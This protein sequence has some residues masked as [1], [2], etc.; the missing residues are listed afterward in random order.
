GFVVRVQS[1]EEL[2]SNFRYL[3]GLVGR[4]EEAKQ[5]EGMIRAKAGGPKG[6]E[7][8]DAKRPMALY[9]VFGEGGLESTTVVG[10]VPIADEKAFLGLIENLGAKSEKDKDGVYAVTGDQVPAPIYFRFAHKHAYV[11][12]LNKDALDKDKILPPGAVL[13]AGKAP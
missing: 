5:I 6:F 11:T 12:A 8:I 9:G 4:D 13:P 2:L 1:L 10:I 3:G 7:G